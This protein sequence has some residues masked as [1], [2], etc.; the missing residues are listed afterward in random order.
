MPSANRLN[1]DTVEKDRV[2]FC[3]A[4]MQIWEAMKAEQEGQ[5]VKTEEHF[6]A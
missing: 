3:C 2:I 1:L 6:Q 5:T 4:K